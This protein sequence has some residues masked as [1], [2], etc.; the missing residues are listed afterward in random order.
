MALRHNTKAP[1]GPWNLPSAPA[2]CVRVYVRV[3]V[4]ELCG[5]QA[6]A[7]PCPLHLNTHP[8]FH[9]NVP[10]RGVYSGPPSPALPSLPAALEGTALFYPNLN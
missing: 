3:C 10:P 6:A 7:T 9:T 2:I 4:P 5:F 8:P 1:E